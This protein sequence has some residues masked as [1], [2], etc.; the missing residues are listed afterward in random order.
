MRS[1]TA[2]A[3]GK[4]KTEASEAVLA[5][6]TRNRTS[7]SLMCEEQ[8][9][10][11]SFPTVALTASVSGNR[12]QWNDNPRVGSPAGQRTGAYIMVISGAMKAAGP[13]IPSENI[14]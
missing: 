6:I 5:A 11:K 1:S 12:I 2:F 8:G 14:A 4:L 10:R 7:Q 13:L 3:C 9:L